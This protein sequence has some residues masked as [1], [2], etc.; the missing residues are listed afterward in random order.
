MGRSAQ[1]LLSSEVM[2]IRRR[3]QPVTFLGLM[4]LGLVVG[5]PAVAE[6]RE[7]TAAAQWRR[8][9]HGWETTQGWLSVSGTEPDRLHPLTWAVFQVLV[10]TTALLAFN[11][12]GETLPF[13]SGQVRIRRGSLRTV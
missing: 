4:I 1:R 6:H 10:S 7:P 11:W 9:A 2:C 8:T 3:S 13:A 5:T 12:D